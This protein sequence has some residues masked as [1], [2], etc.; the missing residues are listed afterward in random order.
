MSASLSRSRVQDILA[1]GKFG[2]FRTRAEHRFL[3]LIEAVAGLRKQAAEYSVGGEHNS[4][5]RG[6]SS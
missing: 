5:N 1:I 4:K 2:S 6:G 3:G